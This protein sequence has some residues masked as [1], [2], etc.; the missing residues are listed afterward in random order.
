[1]SFCRGDSRYRLCVMK[2][3]ILWCVPFTSE[4]GVWSQ[5][6]QHIQSVSQKSKIDT[7]IVVLRIVTPADNGTIHDSCA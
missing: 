3:L 4:V 6:C 5:E 1:M 2:G 7:P